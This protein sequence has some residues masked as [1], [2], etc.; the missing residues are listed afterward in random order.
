MEEEECGGKRSEEENEMKEEVGK[1][2]R[3]RRMRIKG[4]SKT[5]LRSRSRRKWSMRRGAAGAGGTGAE[6]TGAGGIEEQ[7]QEEKEQGA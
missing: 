6:G 3:A 1:K 7:E 5:W 4:S 2:G